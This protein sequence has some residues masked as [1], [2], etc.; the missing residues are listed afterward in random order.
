MSNIRVLINPSETDF[1]LVERNDEVF[2]VRIN[3]YFKILDNTIVSG[4]LRDGNVLTLTNTFGDEVNVVL[5][6][7]DVK[8]L[9]IVDDNLVLTKGN[10]EKIEVQNLSSIDTRVISG[11][12]DENNFLKLVDSKNNVVNIDLN[13]LIGKNQTSD[14]EIISIDRVDSRTYKFN[15]SNGEELFLILDEQPEPP[16]DNYIVKGEIINDELVLT[17]REDNKVIVDISELSN[18]EVKLGNAFLDGSVLRLINTDNQEILVDLSPIDYRLAEPFDTFVKSAYIDDN[19]LFLQRTDDGLVEIDV[20]P[21]VKDTFIDRGVLD[22]NFIN[23]F[24]N[25]NQLVRVD[26]SELLAELNRFVY[27]AYLEEDGD[28]IIFRTNNGVI[29]LDLLDLNIFVNSI[30]LNDNILTLRNNRGSEYSVDLSE[31]R[32]QRYEGGIIDIEGVNDNKLCITRFDGTKYLIDLDDISMPDKP[33]VVSAS[34]DNLTNELSLIR[35]NNEVITVSLNDIAD[36]KTGYNSAKIKDTR[37]ILC[38]KNGSVTELDLSDIF[39]EE[40]RRLMIVELNENILDFY[41]TDGD[42]TSIDLSTL[43]ILKETD[44]FI[45]V[46]LEGKKLVFTRGDLSYSKKIVDLG[47][48]LDRTESYLTNAILKDDSISFSV[49][50]RQN[51]NLD[52]KPLYSQIYNTNGISYLNDKILFKQI[53]LLGQENELEFD[54]SDILT[55]IYSKDRFLNGGKIQDNGNLIL[56]VTNS[57][58]IVVGLDSIY[59]KIY[60]PVTFF[61]VNNST[62]CL[63]SKNEFG[64]TSEVEVDFSGILSDDKFLDR[65]V[66]DISTGI[67]NFYIR[68]VTQPL[69]LD[70]R[71][72]LPE[73][74]N[75][76]RFARVEG[77]NLHVTYEDGSLETYDLARIARRYDTH[78]NTVSTD[79]TNNRLT[80]INNRG[81]RIDVNIE[82]YLMNAPNTY[83]VRGN[84]N[85]GTLNLEYNTGDSFNIDLNTRQTDNFINE[86][87]VNG[88]F[89]EAFYSRGGLIRTDISSLVNEEQLYL[90]DLIIDTELRT[91]RFVLSDQ[92]IATELDLRPLLNDEIFLSNIVSVD[93]YRHEFVRNDETRFILDLDPIR[94]DIDSING[95]TDFIT[96]PANRTIGIVTRNDVFQVDISNFF[97]MERYLID[98]S[99]NFGIQQSELIFNITGV[100]ENIRVDIRP[101]IELLD[102]Y[103]ISGEFTN[104]TLTLTNTRGE[105]VNINTA[106]LLNSTI[107]L[108]DAF[109]RNSDLILQRNN[110]PDLCVKLEPLLKDTDS[111]LNDIEYSKLSNSITFKGTYCFNQLELNLDE[112]FDE[113]DRFL[114]NVSTSGSNLIFNVMNHAI[115]SVDLCE[116]IESCQVYIDEG[117]I[118]SSNEIALKYFN[119]SRPELRISG[120]N[121]AINRVQTFTTDLEISDNRLLLFQENPVLDNPITVDL[122]NFKPDGITEDFFFDPICNKLTLKTNDNVFVEDLSCLAKD[123]NYYVNDVKYENSTNQIIFSYN[124]NE[125][126]KMILPVEPLFRKNDIQPLELTFNCHT[127]ELILLTGNKERTFTKELDPVVINFKDKFVTNGC[128]IPTNGVIE[129]YLQNQIAPAIVSLDGLPLIEYYT[130]DAKYNHLT[131]NINFTYNEPLEDETTGYTINVEEFDKYVVSGVLNITDEA[132]AIELTLHNQNEIVS[133]NIDEIE[134]CFTYV[135]NAEY[136]CRIELQDNEEVIISEIDFYYNNEPETPA[137]SFDL[138]PVFEDLDRYLDKGVLNENSLL[139]GYNENKLGFKDDIEIDLTCLDIYV[140][141]GI[142][143]GDLK[144][145]EL[146][147]KNNDNEDCLVD[148]VIIDV[149]PIMT[150]VVTTNVNDP[151][152]DPNDYK[153]GDIWICEF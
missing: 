125:L 153:E 82:P 136:D 144:Q 46:S 103:I 78:I 127:N 8:E 72:F 9:E 75:S 32:L 71:S 38:A 67:A 41:F 117:C 104:S 95:V 50:G 19:K 59:S 105:I 123:L 4:S 29:R 15:K 23:L 138:L 119:N 30:T 60:R 115:Y 27:D 18:S 134:E 120:L 89:L 49:L 12:L 145:I 137:F 13:G 99:T 68:N 35:D 152:P 126:E 39:T 93:D 76:V 63:V 66:P 135:V 142:S 108:E 88:N 101:A 141:S 80:L 44:A 122:N 61:Q 26:I 3:E 84:V 131:R 81:E 128:Y 52:L 11:E 151:D 16:L 129:L 33:V 148:P 53:N 112:I 47:D 83:V 107:F 121:E 6:G 91:V 94:V 65:I 34:L 51:I 74:S 73:P 21:L 31:L 124:T 118:N 139:L 86:I 36:D 56:T 146:F 149:E 70:I 147:H 25:D 100:A 79:Y 69:Q 57:S 42:K 116:A 140:N 90:D 20:T 45:N 92:S 37:L 111:Y 102:R 85:N 110:A 10:G 7:L 150:K 130:R 113:N 62:Y 1:V 17:D 22:G 77:D 2:K 55:D 40:S 58:P 87:S 96:N 43:P 48:L 143:D 97:P 98:V 132:K 133:I 28:A 106:P 14:T 24:T 54:L 64:E 114:A 5:D 109:I